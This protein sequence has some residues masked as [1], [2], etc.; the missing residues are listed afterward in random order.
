MKRSLSGIKSTG[1]P[2]L[3]NYLGMIR[4][5]IDLQD[6]H[7]AFYFVAEYHA[8]TTE[9]DPAAMR[10]STR[11][12]TAAFLAFG[13]D[14]ERAAFFRQSAVP[15]VTEL[16]WLLSCVTHMGVLE[17][18]HAYKAAKDAG[19]ANLLNHGVFAYPVLMAA[20]ILIYDS[21]VVPVGKDQV[22]HLEMTRLMAR[23]FNTAFGG[24]HLTI[25]EPLVRD[26]VATVPGLDGRKMSK[27]Y[28]NIIEPLA[29]PKAL[30]KQVMKIVTAPTPIEEPLDADAC[31]VFALYALFATPDEQAEMRENYTRPDYGFGH[32]KQALF[33][34]MTAHFE[35]FRAQY[36]TY[37]N[38][39]D[40][41][42]DI[43]AQGARRVRPVVDEVM[44]R[45]RSATGLGPV[46]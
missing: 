19:T 16:A 1:I 25:P 29:P 32:A 3:G 5:A 31:N 36:E 14:P 13:L 41:L 42:E 21:D 22:Q 24:D 4:P 34:K 6:G 46:R 12:I 28:G 23:H 33:E 18:A 17:R 26:E 43:L 40:L 11:M 10:A 35:P 27:S 38:D 15:E 37:L 39:P 7:E 8:L 9:R 44:E 30:R 20:D 45:V 2:H